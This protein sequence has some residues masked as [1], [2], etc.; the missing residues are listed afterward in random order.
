MEIWFLLVV[1]LEGFG[2]IG[3]SLPPSSWPGMVGIAAVGVAWSEAVSESSGD[4]IFA[5]S[6]SMLSLD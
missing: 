4:L 1:V 6:P 2:D 3:S 5:F